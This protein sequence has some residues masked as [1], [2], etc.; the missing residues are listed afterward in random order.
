MSGH[1]DHA[2]EHAADA[3]DHDDDHH[4]PPALPEPPTPLWLTLLGIGLFLAAGIA[5]VATR[6]VGKTTAELTAIPSAE[7]P[8]AGEPTPA[9]NP[10]APNPVAAR[11]PGGTNAAA[12]PSPGAMRPGQPPAPGR[13]PGGGSKQPGHEGHDHD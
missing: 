11:P 8:A 13:A 10:A 4:A 6:D 1:G 3:H 9:P 12:A 2:D 7:A 5:F